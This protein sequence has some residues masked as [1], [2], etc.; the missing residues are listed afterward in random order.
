MVEVLFSSTLSVSVNVSI[1]N[2][3][4][5]IDAVPKQ[6]VL[7]PSSKMNVK[8]TWISKDTKFQIL[9]ETLNIES[10]K[11][12][13]HLVLLG[14]ATEKEL[15]IFFAASNE[16]LYFR[17]I[18]RPE[19]FFI[20]SPILDDTANSETFISR[21]A[22]SQR[23]ADQFAL[24]GDRSVYD[25]MLHHGSNILNSFTNSLLHTSYLAGYEVFQ[26]KFLR[27][28][29]PNILMT[30]QRRYSQAIP[31]IRRKVTFRGDISAPLDQQCRSMLSLAL[32]SIDGAIFRLVCDCLYRPQP[33][34]SALFDLPQV[35][36]T[37]I[38]LKSQQSEIVR[39]LFCRGS[40]G[41]Q[42]RVL[43]TED[44]RT[45]KTRNCNL[46]L[47]VLCFIDLSLVIYKASGILRPLQHHVETVT[48]TGKRTSMTQ[49]RTLTEF[50]NS[51]YTIIGSTGGLS[52]ILNDLGFV[53]FNQTLEQP[54]PISPI[55]SPLKN[56]NIANF[57]TLLP[58]LLL[59]M[60][61]SREY[62][63]DALKIPAGTYEEIIEN[64]KILISFCWPNTLALE[65]S[66]GLNK[67]LASLPSLT[68]TMLNKIILTIIKE[69]QMAGLLCSEKVFLA[70]LNSTIETS[71]I[72]IS[73]QQIFKRLKYV[74]NPSNS[75]IVRTVDRMFNEFKRKQEALARSSVM[76]S[77]ANVL[78]TI[79]SGSAVHPSVT[80]RRQRTLLVTLEHYLSS[81]RYSEFLLLALQMIV[82][83]HG[84]DLNGVIFD[85]RDCVN[86]GLLLIMIA[87]VILP[88][89][90]RAFPGKTLWKFNFA[91]TMQSS[92]ML[93]TFSDTEHCDNDDASEPEDGF[94]CS[95]RGPGTVGPS[96]CNSSGTSKARSSGYVRSVALSEREPTLSQIILQQQERDGY[97]RPERDVLR[98]TDFY[99]CH[100]AFISALERYEELL[101]KWDYSL[102][103]EVFTS[104]HSIL[105]VLPSFVYCDNIREQTRYSFSLF[106]LIDAYTRSMGSALPN[107]S[108]L[109]YY[110][111]ILF[112]T[113]LVSNEYCLTG[114]MKL[115]L[116]DISPEEHDYQTLLSKY[117]KKMEQYRVR[118]R[119]DRRLATIQA[120]CRG[121]IARQYY[122]R[123]RYSALVI[124]HMWRTKLYQ[125]ER[126]YLLTAQAR[127]NLHLRALLMNESRPH[128]DILNTEP[129]KRVL[130]AVLS[131]QRYIRQ[132]SLK[133]IMPTVKIYLATKRRTLLSHK[134]MRAV[135]VLQYYMLLHSLLSFCQLLAEVERI[136]KLSWNDVK[137]FLPTVL[138][139]SLSLAESCDLLE[140]QNDM[141]TTTSPH[142]NRFTR[143][144]FSTQYLHRGPYL[145]IFH[146][147]AQLKEYLTRITDVG[148]IFR[149]G[150]TG[151]VV[152]KTLM[153][154]INRAS[155][156]PHRGINHK[157]S[158]FYSARWMQY[159]PAD[160]LQ[161][162]LSRQHSIE[163]REYVLSAY[164]AEYHGL[165]SGVL[166]IQ[167]YLR[168]MKERLRIKVLQ[169]IVTRML[170]DAFLH[171]VTSPFHTYVLCEA[172][173]SVSLLEAE[174]KTKLG[175]RL[176][177]GQYIQMITL[178]MDTIVVRVSKIQSAFRGCK[179]RTALYRLRCACCNDVILMR[180]AIANGFNYYVL[181]DAEIIILR[182]MRGYRQ[183]LLIDRAIRAA[184]S[185]VKLFIEGAG[186]QNIHTLA[187][188]STFQNRII[189]AATILQSV[190][191]MLITM[192]NISCV[193][194]ISPLLLRYPI[195]CDGL[196]LPTVIFREVMLKHVIDNTVRLQSCA[197][198]YRVRLRQQLLH[199]LV[200]EMVGSTQ[201]VPSHHNTA[202]QIKHLVA[203]QLN[204]AICTP[205]D[206][207]EYMDSISR[208]IVTLQ[209]YTRGW[210]MR[211]K[212]RDRILVSVQI[213][214][215]AMK[216]YLQN[217]SIKLLEEYST[218]LSDIPLL[219]S[220]GLISQDIGEGFRRNVPYL[221]ISNFTILRS[222][223]ERLSYVLAHLRGVV[224]RLRLRTFN[225]VTKTPCIFKLLWY[226]ASVYGQLPPSIASTF[227][228]Y[229]LLSSQSLIIQAYMRR[230]LVQLRLELIQHLTNE[231]MGSELQSQPSIASFLKQAVLCTS[232][233]SSFTDA[234]ILDTFVATVE[235]ITLIQRL[236]RRLTFTRNIRLLK[237]L[238]LTLSNLSPLPFHM[239]IQLF[240]NVAGD[241]L[242]W[243][244]RSQRRSVAT[245]YVINRSLERIRLYALKCL[246][247]QMQHLREHLEIDPNIY[248]M[249]SD[250]TTRSSSILE[251]NYKALDRAACVIQAWFRGYRTRQLL[252][253]CK[254]VLL[255]HCG[256][257]E[258]QL[259][260]IALR[261][262]ANYG[263]KIENIEPVVSA[264][265]CAAKCIQRYYRGWRVRYILKG[266][267]PSL[268]HLLLINSSLKTTTVCANFHNNI[269]KSV[270]V[271]QLYARLFLRAQSSNN[272]AK[273]NLLLQN[274]G[275]VNLTDYLFVNA[276]TG[277]GRRVSNEE[278]YRRAHN[279]KRSFTYLQAFAKGFL[280]RKS[281][282]IFRTLSIYFRLNELSPVLLLTLVNRVSVT[283]FSSTAILYHPS[284]LEPSLK[285]IKDSGDKI[286]QHI[287]AYQ[288]DATIKILNTYSLPIRCYVHRYIDTTDSRLILKPSTC[289]GIA[290]QVLR[291]TIAIQSI[292][293]GYATRRTLKSV[294]VLC[295]GDTVLAQTLLDIILIKV[296]E[297][298]SNVSFRNKRT[299]LLSTSA[300]SAERMLHTAALVLQHAF[301]LRIRQ[302]R[303]I[304]AR[305]YGVEH[306][307]AEDFE[308]RDAFKQR[309]LALLRG[310]CTIQRYYRHRSFLAQLDEYTKGDALL[311][312]IFL[313]ELQQKQ[314][315][316]KIGNASTYKQ[317]LADMQLIDT[318]LNFAVIRIQNMYRGHIARQFYSILRQCLDLEIYPWM[319]LNFLVSNATSRLTHSRI[320]NAISNVCTC[321][322]RIQAYIRGYKQRAFSIAVAGDYAPFLTKQE[323]LSGQDVVIRLCHAID[324][325]EQLISAYAQSYLIRSRLACLRRYSAIPP[326]DQINNILTTRV[327]FEKYLR[328][329]I[330]ASA[331]QR[332]SRGFLT[333][334]SLRQ[335]V[336][337]GTQLYLPQALMTVPS[338]CLLLTDII[339]D[340]TIHIQT[341]ARRHLVSK[342]IGYIRKHLT[343]K[344]FHLFLASLDLRIPSVVLEKIQLILSS[345]SL[346]AIKS[347]AFITR[348][349]YSYVQES[350]LLKL[351]PTTFTYSCY[352]RAVEQIKEILHAIVLIQAGSRGFFVRHKI[353]T[354]K[355]VLLEYG[356][357]LDPV[358]LQLIW[359]RT[360]PNHFNSIATYSDSHY[361]KHDVSNVGNGALSVFDAV[362]LIA[363][364][365]ILIQKYSKGY[366]ASMAAALCR[367]FGIHFTWN[368]GEGFG[369]GIT[370]IQ[371]FIRGW[372]TRA[373][374]ADMDNWER[375]FFVSKGAHLYLHCPSQLDIFRA[376][377][378]EA[379]STLGKICR[380]FIVRSE[381][382]SF[383]H[384]LGTIRHKPTRRAFKN[385]LGLLNT[386]ANIKI[387]TQ[388]VAKFSAVLHIQAHY[389]GNKERASIPQRTWKKIQHIRERLTNSL[390]HGDK[391][392]TVAKQILIHKAI[393][394]KADHPYNNPRSVTKLNYF[395]N[396]Y[397]PS[398]EYIFSRDFCDIII[399]VIGATITTPTL[400]QYNVFRDGCC[401]ITKM[402]TYNSLTHRFNTLN[403]TNFQELIK[404]SSPKVQHAAPKALGHHACA[405]VN[406]KPSLMRLPDILINAIDFN[407]EDNEICA[408]AEELFCTIMQCAKQ[409]GYDRSHFVSE[410]E[411]LEEL[412]EAGLL[413]NLPDI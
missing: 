134:I 301:R 359:E 97:V 331:I 37:D 204:L 36:I 144:G 340:L 314:A 63:P 302:K 300:D 343:K 344:I 228:L 242:L 212:Y 380:G 73:C 240:K 270:Q 312:S 17:I 239:V 319:I 65:A 119:V 268:V 18:G 213:I 220:T 219:V 286:I 3:P 287:I 367:K 402:L 376:E 39:Q 15:N 388:E 58:H 143:L 214:Q 272:L 234:T 256:L 131:I 103:L 108:M 349:T 405:P 387:A 266:I 67:N 237:D 253:V 280:L 163:N 161:V 114:D 51:Y 371:S 261:S 180:I 337:R 305:L 206:I 130:K 303:I 185:A 156:Y 408:D 47:A 326:P 341:S 69:N 176:T 360:V 323:R 291:A 200:E 382:K 365:A 75:P 235:G 13:Q 246:T 221:S 229:T 289:M 304:K 298:A 236:I 126:G 151:Y 46:F 395:C 70:C 2:L 398:A 26:A 259:Q 225:D 269:L 105:R 224:V 350:G 140:L 292:Y 54:H 40:T 64:M 121:F 208:S 25:K 172:K 138:R 43:N 330:A 373:M 155:F 267:D 136:F 115:E 100:L 141:G 310:A 27:E 59:Y 328:I 296:P 72:G 406:V 91:S 254:T 30:A 29:L 50:L 345:A 355:E 112:V 178:F 278:L 348:K 293:R 137:L 165:L 173:R 306:F 369:G 218:L 146:S 400:Q 318:S 284:R 316:H 285:L 356:A 84:Y 188:F 394:F 123:V 277:T 379:A 249:L 152:R 215:K 149:A 307:S 77:N 390:A 241:H 7:N 346:I 364:S 334:C 66:K 201:S 295:A 109:S 232:L 227:K 203:Q 313:S 226:Q 31:A 168:G 205:E 76:I 352:S 381:S 158:I 52:T 276:A 23:G 90:K 385:T 315:L 273:I 170:G 68:T 366:A 342:S 78:D 28:T 222:T 74:F 354:I 8:L 357:A 160:V 401:L 260:R 86:N 11:S 294:L 317:L 193:M 60:S 61:R 88:T 333:V 120:A 336:S 177:M 192:R 199:V 101:Q 82:L 325:A 329:A 125:V 22:L 338:K 244:I 262:L 274:D 187:D 89:G 139:G 255:A 45:N 370:I 396:L 196:L 5:H 353:T 231:L 157:Q 129:G 135:H 216:K 53:W 21:N 399:D 327:N 14:L 110:V 299:A 35:R 335:S 16:K 351:L 124:Q 113:A 238:H 407:R 169:T 6:F 243:T 248:D 210:R 392:K 223:C 184:P 321:V 288:K 233:K 154:M 164:I 264:L 209:A 133:R 79:M 339:I 409:S 153:L 175:K 145:S 191:R 332:Y 32:E 384:A 99:S 377:T 389:R 217:L 265:I 186:I 308:S 250:S 57:R 183:R 258:L 230:H 95:F 257:F 252:S 386:Y 410:Y 322:V 167:A 397:S 19:T 56:E 34:L 148:R 122:R 263:N 87:R 320:T 297:F 81:H 171:D 197:R 159:H 44:Q 362:A 106:R 361:E 282:L 279:L 202:L 85:P 118:T 33:N 92:I 195:V 111:S 372:N 189:H 182:Y 116:L 324:D 181:V 375:D 211:K 162:L 93:S 24:L 247:H 117:A 12:V 94:I 38:L 1:S 98:L 251:R 166:L 368:I 127:R 245:M 179:L 132:R 147:K 363:H 412:C 383:K 104:R 102:Y 142:T 41:L 207:L 62:C 128:D 42:N 150:Y 174:A 49:A 403:Q 404:V 20:S 290:T 198:R 96:N 83:V 194:V 309:E 271:I 283:L 190:A 107:T 281:L 55:I 10:Q 378:N 311:K 358:L 48:A 413:K 80:G 374:F 71:M 275:S 9:N 4:R 347:R 393:L 411:K 391:T